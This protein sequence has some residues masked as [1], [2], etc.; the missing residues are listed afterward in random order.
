MK[1]RW[2]AMAGLSA[3]SLLSVAAAVPSSSYAQDT[4]TFDAPSLESTGSSGDEVLTVAVAPLDRLLPNITH[5]MRLVG[6]GA[7]SG[8]V[9]SAVNGYT[10]GIDR[11]RPIGVFVTLGEAGI[12][13]T[14]AGLPITDLDAFL[15]GL[16]LFGEPEDLGDGLYSMS[17]GPNT[18]FAQDK[19]GWL[20]VSNTE[21]ALE[22]LPSG[23]TEGLQGMVAKNDLWVEV[24]VQNIPDDMVDLLASQ[25]RS[26]F[27]QAME[28]QASGSSDEELEATRAQGEQMMKNL[29]D[30]IA[31]T[32]KFAIGLGIRPSEKS[33]TLDTGAKFVAGSRFA[34]Q[35]DA[36]RG[37]KS[38]MS[39]G[40]SDANMMSL[41]VFSVVAE[42]D[43]A[44]MESTLDTSLKAAYNAIEENSKDKASAER[45]KAYLNRFVKI[46]VDSCKEG[47]L[48]SVVSVSTSPSLNIFAGISV[49]DGSQVESLAK[50]LSDELAKEK[51]PVK[52][53]LM[54]GSHKGV[55]LHKLSAPLP[56]DAE[57]SARKIFGDN[58]NVSI[59]TSPK[60]IYLSVGKTAEASLKSALDGMAA[61]P[62][63][64][65]D[66]MRMR[67]NM[68]QLLN[69]IQS[70]EANPV[71][72]AMLS[73]IGSDDDQ[74]MIDTAMIDRGSITRITIQEGVLKAISGGA[75]AGMA[76]QGGDF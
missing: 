59:G 57:D 72:E 43:V 28:A 25:M 44:Q 17:L 26:G 16:E 5:I 3:A 52:V 49:A 14:V 53:E 63:A 10:N 21:E 8:L 13:V 75:R 67:M 71:V 1:L 27:E 15:G 4:Q 36:T 38:K 61:A 12:P 22:N 41:K 47:S 19:D 39:G 11:E 70:I 29:E 35:I 34:K 9:N 62:S 68:S 46:L 6:A 37:A 31:G 76:G 50:D 18:M 55:T 45:A 42:E 51:A 65:A 74:V 30:A 64:K 48:E 23:S 20:Y 56:E 40:V 66:P 24:N 32:E 58:V 73:S 60:A 54:S 7:Q 2:F 33:V 69:F